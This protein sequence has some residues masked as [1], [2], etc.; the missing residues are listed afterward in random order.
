MKSVF[1]R[2]GIPNE[3]V[4]DNM[5]FFSKECSRFAQEW[6]FKI[7]TF[8]PHYSQS[9]GMS[10]RTIQTIKTASRKADD[11]CVRRNRRHLLPKNESPPN[12]LRP[13]WTRNCRV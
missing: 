9:N 3:V 4:A 2:H 1:A 10:K 8:S 7:S 13:D 12:I 5:P 6:G 11:G